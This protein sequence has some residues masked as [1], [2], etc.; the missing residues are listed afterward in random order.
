KDPLMHGLMQLCGIRV[1]TAFALV[2]SRGNIERFDTPKKLVSYIGLT[3]DHY[4]IE[5]RKKRMQEEPMRVT[6]VEPGNSSIFKDYLVVRTDNEEIFEYRVELRSLKE[7]INTCSCPDFRKNFLGTCKHIEKV[8]HKFSRKSTLSS[9]CTEIFMSSYPWQPVALVREN[10]KGAEFVKKYLTPDGTFRTPE[11]DTLQVMLRKFEG[12]DED[13]RGAIRISAEI[14]DFLL[15]NDEK[16][17]LQRW[18]GEYA[19]RFKKSKG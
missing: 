19:G 18:R 5:L 1:L 14:H 13:V 17:R 9:P 4:E 16:Q 2:V 8:K 10:A 12:L 7:N 3:D 11:A 15:L 6:P